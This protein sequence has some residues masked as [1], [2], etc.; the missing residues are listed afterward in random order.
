M[1]P[2]L[3]SMCEKISVFG[4]FNCCVRMFRLR[5]EPAQR[6]ITRPTTRSSVPGTGDDAS[7]VGMA[8]KDNWAVDPADGRFRYGDILGR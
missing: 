5:P 2:S 8:N 4:K 6:C 7:T 1:R 3:T